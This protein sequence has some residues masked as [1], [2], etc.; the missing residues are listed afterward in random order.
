M[1]VPI[2]A[3]AGITVN[4][5]YCEDCEDDDYEY[6]EFSADIGGFRWWYSI[7][8]DED[9]NE[10][11][12]RIYDVAQLDDKGNYKETVDAKSL[13][14]PATFTAIVT[15]GNN[16]A[17]YTKVYDQEGNFVSNKW[18]AVGSTKEV[19]S[20]TATVTGVY[21]DETYLPTLTSITFPD[22]VEYIN[23]Y[24]DN[25]NLTSVTMSEDV[26][27]SRD[28]F[29][30]TPW[31]ETLKDGDF[32]VRN[33]ILLA[34]TGNAT[35]VTVPDGIT[36]IEANAFSRYYNSNLTNLTSVT[37]A[38]GIEEIGYEAF[39]G[40]YALK[41][42]N[43][44]EGVTSLDYT[45]EGCSALETVTLPSTVKYLYGTF[46]GC[47]SLKSITIPSSVKT[48][49]STFENCTSLKSI[50]IPEGVKS[51]GYYTF[52]DC[53]ALESVS[54]P[55][56]L[57]SI[58][59][60]AF[61]WSG[62][63]SVTI[64]E[65][66]ENIYSYAFYYCEALEKV[67]LPS[68]LEDIRDSAFRNCSSLKSVAIPEGVEYIGYEAFKYC[69]ALESVTLPSTLE[70]IGS[71][72]FQNTAI[73][74]IA[75]PDSLEYINYDAFAY[76]EKLETVTGSGANLD[77]VSSDAFY[78]TPVI[79]KV[80]SGLV[81]VGPIVFT[82]RGEPT[83]T[84]TLPEGVTYICNNAFEGVGY[85][86]G[87]WEEIY[88]DNDEYIGGYWVED[89]T[90]FTVSLPS[91]LKTISSNAFSNS[92]LKGAT[93]GA[94][95]EFVDPS[96]F[97]NT[98]FQNSF[99]DYADDS[100]T[101]FEFVR[102]GKVVLGFKG[103]LPTTLTIPDDVN[104][105]YADV[106]DWD[107][108]TNVTAI[109][110][111]KGL[112]SIASYAFSEMENLATVT[113]GEALENISYRAFDGCS[114]LATVTIDGDVDSISSYAFENC[115]SLTDFTISS[116]DLSIGSD[117]FNNCTNLQNVTVTVLEPEDIDLD[118]EEDDEPYL[119][120][121][122]A[123]FF[124]Q[125]SAYDCAKLANVTVLRH[126]Y[127]IVGWEA[128]GDEFDDEVDT[129]KIYAERKGRDCYW[130]E[131]NNNNVCEEYT[132]YSS[133][134]F[135]P[136]WQKVLRNAEE[137]GVFNGTANTVYQGWLLN[138]DGDMVG[139][140]SVKVM[141]AKNGTSTATATVTIAG[142][143]KATVKGTVD[144][145]GNGAG[146]LAGLV[147][148]ANGLSGAVAVNGATYAIDGARDVTK[149][150]NDGDL[151]VLNALKGKVWTVVLEP[152][153]NI[154]TT[155]PAPANG[156]IGL[157][158]TMGV[159]GKA[160]VSGT[161]PNGVKVN[162][163]AQTI[164]GSDT[165]CIPVV[166]SKAKDSFAFLLWVDRS[167]NAVEISNLSPWK[168]TGPVAFN[169][170][171]EVT[172]FNNLIPI[173]GDTEF[174]VSEEDMPVIDGLLPE[175]LPVGEPIKVG[176]RWTVNKPAMI[177]FKN[178]VFDQAS[179]DKGVATGKTNDSALK[180][181][182]TAKTGLFK[183]SFKVYVL[184]GGKL[185]KLTATV[186]GVVNSGEGFGSAL[187]KKV[188]VAPVWIGLPEED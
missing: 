21:F 157:S 117:V 135:Q 14:V 51:I 13:T 129:F 93:G 32:V 114:K 61:A 181:N 130:D 105:F 30:G 18:T 88:D 76:C 180:V 144:A 116:S 124:P 43:I 162:V 60:Y 78:N 109:A 103:V 186:F 178:G 53:T 170:E 52:E 84:I 173:V 168:C 59:G 159:K 156:Y 83:E 70:E 161:L 98:E 108:S 118:D 71:C 33:G 165:C 12:A 25:T 175:F 184:Q 72:A 185:K 99:Y 45:F 73:A 140:V 90:P 125:G 143:K 47:S 87:Y 150:K 141:K 86:G 100:K 146:A 80:E 11:T 147:F 27:F 127:K 151:A 158:V 174:T 38:E 107:S 37:L 154:L 183:G 138:E 122:S 9:D 74:S 64:P 92:G 68:T 115:G 121:S 29:E 110:L 34:Y 22:S 4:N 172:A 160:K 113:G 66:V 56:T 166:Y 153:D 123:A 137:D 101:A 89:Y 41:S 44:P 102:V 177:K 149:T 2:T 126:G 142:A 188:G 55:S 65:G 119:S 24:L 67:S 3:T 132:Y 1:A 82:Y 7:D 136:E 54:L 5:D 85:N 133:I 81:R 145:S 169:T 97:N 26:R 106:N 134:Y 35:E 48:L 58:G 20:L 39:D 164:V 131:E 15:N 148:G 16:Y 49:Y 139:A 46:Y 23:G 152:L 179:Y 79:D 77:W 95:V 10:V 19:T 111:G 176:T 75:L 182:Y 155:I 50:T 104:A 8:I 17:T 94:N 40:C 62:L 163:N 28:V 171:L 63:K 187:I 42:V 112:E 57:E 167:G 128:Y 69:T 6:G 96:A 120:I 31:F 36:A 91:T